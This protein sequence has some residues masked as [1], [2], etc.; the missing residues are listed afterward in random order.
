MATRSVV[1]CTVGPAGSG[2]SFR[3]CAHF[4]INEFLPE[5]DGVHWSNF[6]L[7]KV[8]EDHTVPPEYDGETFSDRIANRAAAMHGLDEEQLH[9]RI[10]MIPEDE[11]KRWERGE[12]G[13]WEFFEGKNLQDAH[14]AI[15][16]IHN[17][18]DPQA[19][20]EEKR[21][22]R[23]WLG[24]IRH[25]GATVEFISQSDQKIAIELRRESALLIE[26]QN[27]ET[28]K[29]PI[30]KI[31]LGDWYELR[32]MILRRYNSGVQETVSR[33]AV[34][35]RGARVGR[36]YFPLDPWYFQFYDSYSKP[37][38]GGNK[39]RAQRRQWQ[40]RSPPG[41][42]AWFVARNM[43]KLAPRV[44][45]AGVM[46]WILFFGGGRTIMNQAFTRAQTWGA[47]TAKGVGDA[48]GSD[49]SAQPSAEVV[50]ASAT[51]SQALESDDEAQILAELFERLRVRYNAL[52]E[53][54]RRLQD[55][56]EQLLDQVRDMSALV[57]V[58]ANSVTL[59][60]GYT[61]GIGEVIDYGEY[62]GRKL[63]A[64]N[65]ARRTATLDN[66]TVLRLMRV[67]TGSRG[68]LDAVSGDQ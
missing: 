19:K 24:E 54:H 27:T 62:R 39:G 41:L 45:I 17:F 37:Q 65:Q 21:K 22:W 68:L 58:T 66:N 32:A 30:F 36:K 5:H 46:V 33:S 25:Q 9:E 50:E 56:H 13:P 38:K 67:G 10:K 3:R 51:M 61:Y 14:I 43:P 49:G 52:D 2:K 29:D 28:L 64:I 16:E 59:R 18:L 1:T 60:S 44:A 8:P 20:A 53:R 63:V 47:E 55:E 26:L 34:K 35:G 23:Q 40:R 48:Y 15:D 11:L 42:L 31:E 12:S 4:I 6:P 7:G 57:A